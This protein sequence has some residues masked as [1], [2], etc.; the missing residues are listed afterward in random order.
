MSEA[1]TLGLQLLDFIQECGLVYEFLLLRDVNILSLAE[2]KIDF[3]VTMACKIIIDLTWSQ[4]PFRQILVH[5]Y[6]LCGIKMNIL[7][8]ILINLQKVRSLYAFWV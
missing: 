1:S 7:H 8:K 4:L 5:P 3:V 6:K 2:L